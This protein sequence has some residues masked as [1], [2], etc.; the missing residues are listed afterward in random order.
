[1]ARHALFTISTDVLL[2]LGQGRY[3]VVK[4]PVPNDAVLIS[5]NANPTQVQL[6]I[7]HASFADIADGCVLPHIDSPLVQRL[8]D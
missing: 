1:M 4:N 2:Q 8:E 7:E 5:I 6:V 3:E